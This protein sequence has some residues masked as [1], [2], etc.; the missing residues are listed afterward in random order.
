MKQSVFALI[1][2]TKFSE[3]QIA[4]IIREVLKGID[5]L[6]DENRMH[7]DIKS[8]N[9]LFNQVGDIKIIDFGFSTQLTTEFDV[10]SSV[11]GT[12]S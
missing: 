5:W 10:K 4:Y 11:V 9:I 8:D 1:K 12:P 2:Q 6:H 7:R 3:S